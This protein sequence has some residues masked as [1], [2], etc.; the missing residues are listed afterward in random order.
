ML[1]GAV[2]S[3]LCIRHTAT[4]G[5]ILK[6]LVIQ[7]CWAEIRTYYLPDNDWMNYGRGFSSLTQVVV[8]KIHFI[9]LLKLC[10]IVISILKK[11]G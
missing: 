10:Y 11:Q 6:S 5:T 2:I 3:M 9:I 4:V 8:K 7:Q 1:F